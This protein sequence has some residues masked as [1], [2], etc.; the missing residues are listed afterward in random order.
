MADLVQALDE[1]FDYAAEVV[2]A[3][4][5]EHL[6]APTPCP[7]WDLGPCCGT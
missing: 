2:K 3:V 4:R 5:P 1:A 7:E 6:G